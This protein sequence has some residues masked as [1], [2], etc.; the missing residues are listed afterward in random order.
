MSIDKNFLKDYAVKS[1]TS[2]DNVVR[3]YIQNLFLRSFY[4]KIGSENFLFKGG[5]ALRLVFGSPRFSEDLDFTGV[6]NSGKY[7]S[8]LESVLLELSGEGIVLDL[9]E[10]KTTTGGHLGTFIVE[11]FEENIEIQNHISFR[12]SDKALAENVVITSDVAPAYKVV[13]LDRGELV[14]E[15][16]NA[17]VTRSKPRDFFDLYFFLRNEPLRRYV[18]LDKIKREKILANL[19]KVEKE[20]L[21]RE[22]KKFLPRSFWTIIKD[23]PS[24]LKKELV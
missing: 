5:T 22:L 19:E 23:L 15:K 12:K 13:I 6:K 4:T 11:L 2:L 24:A 17:L 14:S 16:L 21:E 1:E 3:E 9:S 7:E 8:V 20:K 10:S 18:K